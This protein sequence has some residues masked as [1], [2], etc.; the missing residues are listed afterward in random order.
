LARQVTPPKDDDFALLLAAGLVGVV[1]V[2]VLAMVYQNNEQ[3]RATFLERLATRL[4][5][6][7]LMFVS[8]TF[9]RAVGNL[10]VWR[11]TLQTR[12]GGVETLRLVLPAGTEPYAEAAFQAVVDHV[13]AHAS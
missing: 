6:H 1:G 13:V 9:G 2:G 4:H 7:G 11:V 5:E 8:A 10:P 3:R 12:D